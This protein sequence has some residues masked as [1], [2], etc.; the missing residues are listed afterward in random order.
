MGLAK[1]WRAGRSIADPELKAAAKEAFI[2]L[3]RALDESNTQDRLAGRI[4]PTRMYL[5]RKNAG[6]LE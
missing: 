1:A 2:M 4:H 6:L 3:C 5:K